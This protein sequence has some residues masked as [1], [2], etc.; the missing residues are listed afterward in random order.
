MASNKA[1]AQ[2]LHRQ[3]VARLSTVT[4]SLADLLGD[5]VAEPLRD[6]RLPA[7]S[8]L[9][10]P[11]Q[12]FAFLRCVA[13]IKNYLANETDA[14]ASSLRH[15]VA[16]HSLHVRPTSA[17]SLITAKVEDFSYGNAIAIQ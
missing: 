6:V 1:L 9:R 2:K 15:T 13:S 8:A 16:A 7:S 3:A 4:Q 11:R 14:A 5:K 12:R 10:F 17:V